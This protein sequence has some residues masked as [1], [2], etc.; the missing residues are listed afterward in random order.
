MEHLL[1]E[2]L[3]YLRHE[4]GASERT[5]VTYSTVLHRLLNWAQD[6]R[7]RSWLIAN[8]Y[9]IEEDALLKQEEP[10]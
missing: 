7:I 4:R 2:F 9:R 5:Q 1:D 6:R 8:G 3:L 10:R